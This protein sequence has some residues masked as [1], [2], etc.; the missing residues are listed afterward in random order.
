MAEKKHFGHEK[1]Y[2]RIKTKGQNRNQ[3]QLIS[4][5]TFMW[6]ILID[7]HRFVQITGKIFM[8]S[9][10]VR[11]VHFNSLDH[12]TWKKFLEVQFLDVLKVIYWK[13]PALCFQPVHQIIQIAKNA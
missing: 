5:R 8:R 12:P 4:F 2:M 3:G 9:H 6:T 1:K 11:D 10:L 13:Q 7:Y